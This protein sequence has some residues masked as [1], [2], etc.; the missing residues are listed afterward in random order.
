MGGPVVIPHL[1][2]GKN[3]TFFF[4]GYQG[5]RIRN[6]TS[7]SN[8]YVP[9]AAE[10]NGDFSA[11]Q[12][13]SDPANPFGKAINILDP[14]TGLP[15]PNNRI[16]P[17]R[18]DPAAVAFTKYLPVGTGNGLVFYSQPVAQ[19]FNEYLARVVEAVIKA[20][21]TVCNIPD[22]TGYC[23]PEQYGQKMAFLKNHVPNIDKAILSCHCHNDLGLATANSIAGAV[24]GAR[25]IE[26]TINGLGE[27]AGTGLSGSEFTQSRSVVD[28]QKCMESE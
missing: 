23:L 27:R 1:Y 6:V 3:R 5:T 28:V 11:L 9:T 2:N 4:F 19:D 10:L 22:T 12:N 13:A 18:F 14:R 8:A 20:G 21:A 25:Q 7:S 26:C 17:S 16:D 15:F 24:A